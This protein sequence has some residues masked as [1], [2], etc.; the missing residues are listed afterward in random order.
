MKRQL[1]RFFSYFF[2]IILLW[3][4]RL[5]LKAVI[6]KTLFSLF[7]FSGVASCGNN[8]YGLHQQ[9][10]VPHGNGAKN[11]QVNFIALTA[12]CIPGLNQLTKH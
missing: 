3:L 6:T 7:C 4:C 5:M 9:L 12:S 2:T 11:A 10:A 1:S 8:L